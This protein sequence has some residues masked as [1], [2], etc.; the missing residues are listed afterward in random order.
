MICYLLKAKVLC[1]ATLTCSSL[2]CISALSYGTTSFFC[3]RSIMYCCNW[4]ET[5]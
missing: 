3:Y 5:E 4:R 2:W 1:S